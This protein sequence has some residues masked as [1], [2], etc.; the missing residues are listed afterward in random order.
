MV[1]ADSPKTLMPLAEY[2]VEAQD[3]RCHFVLSCRLGD[4]V[5]HRVSR[6]LARRVGQRNVVQYFPGNRTDAAGRNSV[7]RKRQTESEGGIHDVAA[8]LHDGS[9]SIDCLRIVNH[10]RNA[11]APATDDLSRKRL[12]EI[13][14]AF[15]RRRK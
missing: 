14:T 7:V 3:V 9:P 11:H 12:T 6:I 5:V 2:V 15:E 13:P 4:V 1:P 10:D 8:I